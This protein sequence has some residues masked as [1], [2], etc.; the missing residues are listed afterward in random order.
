MPHNAF[1]T[2]KTFQPAEGKKGQYYSL[3]ALAQKGLPLARALPRQLAGL[4]RPR[5][6]DL[7]G[8][9]VAPSFEQRGAR[10]HEL[11]DQI[12]DSQFSILNSR[13]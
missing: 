1:D 2:F 12:L 11:I 5:Q 10:Q 3:P 8:A 13:L 6:Q 9:L 7:P 4:L